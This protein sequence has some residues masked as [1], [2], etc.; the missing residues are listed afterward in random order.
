MRTHTFNTTELPEGARFAAW[1]D[2]IEHFRCVSL[3]SRPFSADV[4][5]WIV[6]RLVI[7]Q[8]KLTPVAFLRDMRLVQLDQVDHVSLIVLLAGRCAYSADG[9]TADCGPGDVILCDWLRASEARCTSQRSVT[10]VFP[11]AFLEEATEVPRGGRL[12]RSSATRLLAE[13]VAALVKHLPDLADAGAILTARVLRDLAAAALMD[14]APARALAGTV[15]RRERV[16]HHIADLPVGTLDVAALSRTL[17]LSRSALYRLFRREG[18]VL[19][20]DRRRRLM[21]LHGCLVDPGERR[22]IAELG[23]A[24]GFH[25]PVQLSQLFRRA[26]GYSASALRSNAG[27][28][29]DRGPLQDTPEHYRGAVRDL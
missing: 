18:G 7:T 24:Q 9:V 23:R 19:A 16:K 5:F 14:M 22:G 8:L 15:A 27:A 28:L 21:A 10:I 1:A 17:G 11:R 26:F 2:P 25:D 12:P 13:H 3:S 4:R 20:Y 6:D 29:R